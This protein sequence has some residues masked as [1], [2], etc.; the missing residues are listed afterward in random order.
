MLKTTAKKHCIHNGVPL[1]HAYLSLSPVVWILCIPYNHAPLQH[2]SQ[3]LSSMWLSQTSCTS[4]C[5]DIR[6]QWEVCCMGLCCV[7]R[8]VTLIQ[9]A[10]IVVYIAP[11]YRSSLASVPRVGIGWNFIYCFS[12]SELLYFWI[13]MGTRRTLLQVCSL[14]PIHILVHFP[15]HISS[16][17]GGSWFGHVCDSHY[18]HIS[19]T[20]PS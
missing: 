16:P 9:N 17:G 18:C 3:C 10:I 7:A 12:V 5:I 2:V 15:G 19:Q 14:D 11:N 8:C 1:Y 4:I 13:C 20:I 6:T